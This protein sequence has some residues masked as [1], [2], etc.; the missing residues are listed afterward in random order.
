MWWSNMNLI[1]SVSIERGI[2][3][4]NCCN[5]YACIRMHLRFSACIGSE[6]SKEFWSSIVCKCNRN[7][8]TAKKRHSNIMHIVSLIFNNILLPPPLLFLLLPNKY[9]W[10][11]LYTQLVALHFLFKQCLVAHLYWFG[12]FLCVHAYRFGCNQNT[13]ILFTETIFGHV[14]Q[15]FFSLFAK[16][17]LGWQENL[18]SFSMA[19]LITNIF[20]VV[21]EKAV[22][23]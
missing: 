13:P 23:F 22:F 6:R 17:L 1:Q 15:L 19:I 9:R 10:V 16:I 8:N 11:L 18:F 5:S 12:I 20:F 2:C 14:L 21:E 7:M 4:V 3:I